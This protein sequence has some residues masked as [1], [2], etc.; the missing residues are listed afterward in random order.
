M[1]ISA[2][3]VKE[4]REKTN[5]GMM[6]CKKALNECDGDMEAAVDWLRKKG[7]SAAA[8]KSGRVASEGLVGLASTGNAAAIVEINAETDFVSKNDHFQTMVKNVAAIAAEQDYTIE[9]LGAAGYEHSEAGTVS[10]ELVRLIAMI[11]ENMNLRRVQRLSVENGVVSSYVHSAIAPNLG[12]IGVLVALESTADKAVLEDLGK[13]IAM[14]VAAA[15]PKAL[16]VEDLDSSLVEKERQILIEQA[17]ASGRPDNVIE[18]M[19][20]G[21]IQKFYKESV[22]L[23]Q[24]FVMDG[25]TAVKD[26][27]AEAAKEAGTDI[28]LKAFTCYTLG[29]GIEK[30]EENFAEEV[31]AQI[32]SA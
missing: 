2:A 14:H 1:A 26:V 18:K 6:D 22:L 9:T 13:K 17:K 4:L 7:L 30:K 16:T 5:A 19:V 3:L 24:A 21:R 12:R 31:Q 28:T 25:K 10:E 32:K 27:I 20:E 29:E 23:E 15:S 11:G 8:K